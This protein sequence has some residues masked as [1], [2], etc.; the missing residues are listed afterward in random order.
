MGSSQSG[1]VTRLSGRASGSPPGP[2][3]WPPVPLPPPPEGCVVL[4]HAARSD[5]ALESPSAAPPDRTR[6]S[7]RVLPRSFGCQ[8]MVR[9][10]LSVQS[11]QCRL[12]QRGDAFDLVVHRCGGYRRPDEIVE[13]LE[14]VLPCADHAG[15]V[16]ARLE[17]LLDAFGQLVVLLLHE[18]VDARVEPSHEPV[19][20][21][22]RLRRPERVPD[23]ERASL[24]ERI[25]EPEVDLIGVQVR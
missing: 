13:V 17:P 16:A 1:S 6:K 5:P 4:P 7:R 15:P 21:A 19:A 25:V 2:D 23:R 12:P 20:P 14:A 18:V 11:C 9:P 24:V 3:G 22:R 10:S 8:V